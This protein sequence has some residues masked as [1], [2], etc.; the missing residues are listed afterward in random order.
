MNTPSLKLHSNDLSEV[1]SSH[2]QPM[3]SGQF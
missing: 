1:F 3:V 2:Q